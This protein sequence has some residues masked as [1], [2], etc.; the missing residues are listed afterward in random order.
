MVRLMI[1]RA[2]LDGGHGHL[3]GARQN[4]ASSLDQLSRI[5][6]SASAAKTTIIPLSMRLKEANANSWNGR[7]EL[8]MMRPRRMQTSI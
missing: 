6:D 2:L 4:A 3:R 5:K 7:F 1:L 8:P